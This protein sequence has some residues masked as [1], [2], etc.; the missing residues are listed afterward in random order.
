[1][2]CL[3]SWCASASPSNFVTSVVTTKRTYLHIPDKGMRLCVLVIALEH[4][5]HHFNLL[6][7]MTSP[8]EQN[9][10]PNVLHEL[11]ER[12]RT[13]L[14]L[15]SVKSEISVSVLPKAYARKDVVKKKSSSNDHK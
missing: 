7:Y 13:A 12:R 4:F 3:R 9:E 1:M 8:V 2:C 10:P 14:T 15:S 5:S 11:V 6:E